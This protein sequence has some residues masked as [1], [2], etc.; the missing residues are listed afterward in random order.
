[1][2]YQ[3]HIMH[4]E[5]R[6]KIGKKEIIRKNKIQESTTM[7]KNL[8]L[9]ADEKLVQ[10]VQVAFTGFVNTRCNYLAI[11]FNYNYCPQ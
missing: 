5:E 8:V 1:M 3:E 4:S 9:V 2:N 11:G 6:A 7:E 10:S